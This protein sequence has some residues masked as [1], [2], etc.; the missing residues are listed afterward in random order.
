MR[1]SRSTRCLAKSPR[2]RTRSRDR[3]ETALPPPL[4]LPLLVHVARAVWS[5]PPL[6]PVPGGR[7]DR[8][9][10]V[11]RSCPSSPR[12]SAFALPPRPAFFLCVHETCCVLTLP[13]LPLSLPHQGDR[14]RRAQLACVLRSAFV[15]PFRGE[16]GQHQGPLPL[17]ALT[18]SSSSSSSSSSHLLLI[19]LT[20]VMMLRG[21]V[22]GQQGIACAQRT[23]GV[24]HLLA[25]SLPRQLLR[26]LQVQGRNRHNARG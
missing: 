7:D 12:D 18:S 14:G 22:C 17:S 20:L 25:E 6:T 1:C 21:T 5:C 23:R 16:R 15:L 2:R 10:L 9:C 4:R 24:L 13:P 3:Y 26:P 8:K 11:M 19:V